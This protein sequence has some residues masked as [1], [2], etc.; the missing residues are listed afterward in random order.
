MGP[1][2]HRA[3]F[4][5]ALTDGQLAIVSAIADTI[6]PRTDSPGATDVGVPAFVDAVVSENFD[7]GERA[8]FV[9]GLDALDGL[10]RSSGGVGFADLAPDARATAIGAIEADANHHAEPAHTYW[11]LKGLIV[12]GYFTSEPVMKDVL[13]VQ[14]MPGKFDGAAPMPLRHAATQPAR[15]L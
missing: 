13:H 5:G 3:S 4:A 1:C 14:V 6:L 15:Q 12:H 2:R 10:A 11:R 7:D 8:A 9:S